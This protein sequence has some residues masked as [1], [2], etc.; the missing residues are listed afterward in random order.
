MGIYQQYKAG[1]LDLISSDFTRPEENA[2][3]MR[4]VLFT[5]S[6][7]DPAIEKRF[8]LK[9]RAAT[10]PPFGGLEFSRVRPDNAVKENE[11]LGFFPEGLKRLS[12]ASITV[13]YSGSATAATLTLWFDPATADFRCLIVEDGVATYNGDLGLGYEEGSPV[14]INALDTAISALTGL[15]ATVSGTG[16]IPA[17]FL[18]NVYQ[19][20]LKAGPVTL[21]AKEWTAV[22]IGGGRYGLYETQLAWTDQDDYEPISHTALNNC[23]YFYTDGILH[24]YDGQNTFEAGA[25]KPS[26]LVV[27]AAASGSIPAGTYQ[28]IVRVRQEDSAG[29]II[30][31]PWSDPAS[32]TLVATRDINVNYTVTSPAGIKETRCDSTMGSPS[33]TVPVA[34]D[35]FVANDLVCLYDRSTSETLRLRVQSVSAGNIVLSQAVQLT[36]GDAVTLGTSVEIARTKVGG[37]LFYYVTDTPLDWL[38]PAPAY[39]DSTLDSALTEEVTLPEFD[40]GQAPAGKYV[41]KYQGGLVVSG[42]PLSG[43]NRIVRR[44]S[45]GVRTY[46]YGSE[47]DVSFADYENYEGF[48]IDGSFTV[49]VESDQGD[50]VRGLAECGNSLI[51]FKDQS[52]ARLSG[53]PT[54]LDIKL[55][56]LSKEVGCLAGHTIKEINGQLMFLSTRGFATVNESSA[57]SEKAGFV[58][59]PIIDNANLPEDEKLRFLAGHTCLLSSRQLYLSYFPAWVDSDDWIEEANIQ[60]DVNLGD[61]ADVTID[62]MKPYES[63]NGR[64]FCYDYLRGR[65]SEWKINA[66]GAL[67]EAGGEL[68]FADIRYSALASDVVSGFFMENV[69]NT[70]IMYQDHDNEISWRLGT[71]WYHGG[72]PSVPKQISRIRVSSV[73]RTENNSP[74]MDVRQQVN[75][76]RT[77]LCEVQLP[78]GL[79]TAPYQVVAQSRLA[80]GKYNSTRIILE[81]EQDNT[82]VE[83]EGW[84]LEIDAPYISELKT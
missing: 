41:A 75:Y 40:Y 61:G 1:T 33:T 79:Q 36:S 56:W 70:G 34:D 32:V 22:G 25:D 64:L 60:V 3:E 19:H 14:T 37:A 29:N 84:E 81:N 39:L 2:S 31:G 24:K 71:A 63:G 30:Y 13:T 67:F 53:D 43:A 46:D 73:P 62:V 10:A 28:Y 78:F 48:P 7:E 77:D 74:T 15:A 76:R 58:I 66:A 82:N 5:G 72:K 44:G 65:W 18:N 6:V 12:D 57:P 16:T 83:V 55:D 80:D 68:A 23:L 42:F 38:T 9:R 20:D 27:S 21:T 49:S 26:S 54:E 11:V 8:G 17:A 52:T 59:R 4:N 45:Y 35:V 47:N 50:I 51:V 69:G